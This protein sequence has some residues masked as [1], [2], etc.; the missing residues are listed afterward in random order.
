MGRKKVRQDG[1]ELH[2][3]LSPQTFAGM[4]R[5]AA[6]NN[7]SMNMAIENCCANF[8]DSSV[9]DDSL[10][11]ARMSGLEQGL[12]RL[13]GKC[14]TFFKL[15][16]SMCPFFLAHLPRLPRDADEANAVLKNGS[17]RMTSLIMNFRKQERATDISF[18]QQIWGD[19]QEAV[20]EEY[21]RG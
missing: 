7:I 14:E 8:L 20:A 6:E 1:I 15:I 17:A 18:V 13:D 10:I 12:S 2:I 16:A 4:K 5:Y 21:R 9:S 19:I 11:L 3:N